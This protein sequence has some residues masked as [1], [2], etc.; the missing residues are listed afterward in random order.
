MSRELTYRKLA[1]VSLLGIDKGGEYITAM[2]TGA[3]SGR[4]YAA[5]HKSSPLMPTSL[6]DNSGAYDTNMVTDVFMIPKMK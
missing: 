4:L 6:K 1:S 5:I 3:S 2:H